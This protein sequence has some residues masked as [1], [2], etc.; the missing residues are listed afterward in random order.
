MVFK[1]FETGVFT[2]VL[3]GKNIQHATQSKYPTKK[4]QTALSPLIFIQFKILD[5]WEDRCDPECY[6]IY[7]EPCNIY[8]IQQVI[9]FQIFFLNA[10]YFELSN[11]HPTK[12]Y[13]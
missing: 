3:P 7:K 9:E 6:N 10:I 8:N 5:R 11:S 12:I 2:F 1:V 4:L 13:Q